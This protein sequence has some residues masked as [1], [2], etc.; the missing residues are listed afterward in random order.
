MRHEPLD[1][2]RMIQKEC[3]LRIHSE[4]GD[5]AVLLRQIL[6]IGQRATSISE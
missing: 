4:I 2:I 3:F 6:K 5:V 1:E